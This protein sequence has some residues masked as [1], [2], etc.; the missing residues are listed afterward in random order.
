MSPNRYQTARAAL[1][2]TQAHLAQAA[3]VSERTVRRLEQGKEISAENQ[4]SICAVLGLVPEASPNALPNIPEPVAPSAASKPETARIPG[5]HDDMAYICT[6]IMIAS[7]IWMAWYFSPIEKTPLNLHYLTWGG[8]WL[9][10]AIAATVL[11]AF[12]KKDDRVAILTVGGASFT[13]AAV[14]AIWSRG[15]SLPTIL[16]LMAKDAQFPFVSWL[17]LVVFLL[18]GIGMLVHAEMLKTKDAGRTSSSI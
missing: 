6:L 13:I 8:K 2:M 1:V 17:N 4:R 3:S 15:V 9:A 12:V 16:D 10:M 18:V 7:G 5:P 11:T 14:I